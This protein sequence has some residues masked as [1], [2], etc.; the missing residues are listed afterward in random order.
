LP[1]SQWTDITGAAITHTFDTPTQLKASLTGAIDLSGANGT[2]YVRIEVRPAG[3]TPFDILPSI[4]LQRFQ[5][6]WADSDH[7]TLPFATQGLFEVPAGE[8]TIVPVIWSNFTTPNFAQMDPHD[9][10][11]IVEQ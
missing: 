7:S 11:L 2:V 8:V 4:T 3:G 10:V 5:G 1:V 6:P 9:V